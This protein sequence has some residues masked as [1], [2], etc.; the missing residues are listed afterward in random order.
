MWSNGYLGPRKER[1]GKVQ[2]SK[3][4]GNIM[5]QRLLQH[6][7]YHKE[8]KNW[9]LN[10][11]TVNHTAWTFKMTPSTGVKNVL[12]TQNCIGILVRSHVKNLK[13]FR[14]ITSPI[15]VCII[16][17]REPMQWRGPS[18]NGRNEQFGLFL[19]SSG[20]K[21]S[22]RNSSGWFRDHDGCRKREYKSPGLF[23]IPFLLR[24]NH[25]L[26]SQF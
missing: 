13:C 25:S 8:L 20:E 19:I 23:A 12:L 14:S 26:S 15:R 4:A 6:C 1:K 16:A 5:L 7:S 3:S 22:G 18:P 24:C 2:R 21:R 17:N 11:I 9:F 10:R